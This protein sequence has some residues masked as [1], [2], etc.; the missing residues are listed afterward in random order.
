MPHT[1]E[2]L[3]IEVSV[4]SEVCDMLTLW[5]QKLKMALRL[6]IVWGQDRSI[7]LRASSYAG[8]LELKPLIFKRPYEV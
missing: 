3:G 5:I 7:R 8:K 1:C 6:F 4:H 2:T